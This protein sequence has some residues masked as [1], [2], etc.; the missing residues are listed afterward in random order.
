MKEE[1]L[2]R[3]SRVIVAR[4]VTPQICLAAI[5]WHSSDGKLSLY[6]YT[7]QE[8]TDQDTGQV[9]IT[10]TE[11]LAEFPDVLKCETSCTQWFGHAAAG[12]IVFSAAAA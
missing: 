4:N 9:E 6:Y 12:H 8:P 11:L 10:M 1:D 5:A 7:H 3:A 2:L